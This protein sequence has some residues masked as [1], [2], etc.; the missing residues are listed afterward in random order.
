MAGTFMHHSPTTR[1]VSTV[2][3]VSSDLVFAGLTLATGIR[4]PA[5]WMSAILAGVW[6]AAGA[7]ELFLQWLPVW[8]GF[9][10]LIAILLA[11]G[12]WYQLVLSEPKAATRRPNLN[13][14]KNRARS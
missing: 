2:L 7:W 14:R 9:P 6:L 13:M 12:A 1:S 10:V 5:R 8:T 11:A 4:R 3:S